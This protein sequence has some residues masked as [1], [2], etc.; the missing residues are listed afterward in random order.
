MDYWSQALSICIC[1]SRR[2][3]CFL[4]EQTFYSTFLW[5]NCR[6]RIFS[7]DMSGFTYWLCGS[8]GLGSWAFIFSEGLGLRGTTLKIHQKAPVTVL[9]SPKSS[10]YV[11]YK[12]KKK[13][14]LPSLTEPNTLSF[15]FLSK[16][17]T[18]LTWGGFQ[19]Q[20][21]YC[22]SEKQLTGLGVTKMWQCW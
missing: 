12:S 2:N 5:I 15:L 21:Q 17:Q 13:H 8:F 18:H 22:Q 7:I 16:T 3:V 6:F 9:K 14:P 1:G 4:L 11:I 20:R 10:Y 19:Q